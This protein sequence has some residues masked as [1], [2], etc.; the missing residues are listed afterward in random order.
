MS[1]DKYKESIELRKLYFLLV[2]EKFTK[3]GSHLAH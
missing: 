3:Y 2:Q 1:G